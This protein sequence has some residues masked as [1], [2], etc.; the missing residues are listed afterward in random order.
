MPSF[1]S[2]AR[3][4]G[5]ERYRVFAWPRLYDLLLLVLTRGRKRAYREELL[6]VAGV[7][8]GHRVLDVGC[9]T[10]AQTVA[11]GRRVRPGGTAVGVDL[12]PDMLAVARRKARRAGIGVAFHHADAAAL[13]F[14]DGRFDVVTITTVLHAVPERRR[15]LCLAESSRVLRS[16]G[17]LLLVDYAGDPEDRRGWIAKHGPHRSFD[18]HDMRR[19]LSEG[20]FR[21]IDDG[22]L[23]WLGL[24]YLRGTKG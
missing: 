8:P 24:H 3:A 18:L 14:D 7:A 6:D 5:G 17:R 23:S 10:G 2:S 21:E 22:P 12:S 1:S 19:P 20:G 13:P 16:G 4:D 11:A 9:G 15:R